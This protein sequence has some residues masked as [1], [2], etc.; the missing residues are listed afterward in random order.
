MTCSKCLRDWGVLYGDGILSPCCSANLIFS[1]INSATGY[2][3]STVPDEFCDSCQSKL[4]FNRVYLN[5]KKFCSRCYQ[6]EIN[7]QKSVTSWLCARCGKSNNPD[8]QFC[9]CHSTTTTIT[10]TAQALQT[11]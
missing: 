4:N 7:K 11:R 6:Q 2:T 5:G 10:C 1:Y 9:D 3:I 8:R